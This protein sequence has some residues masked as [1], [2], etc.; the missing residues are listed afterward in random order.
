MPDPNQPSVTS[1]PIH[2][3]STMWS[4]GR[5]PGEGG[6][7]DMPSFARAAARLGYL[8]IEVNYVIPEAGVHALLSTDHVTI[9]SFHSPTPRIKT[10]DG[11]HSDALNLASLDQ[12]ERALAVQRALTTIDSAAQ[13]GARYVVVHLGGVEGAMLDEERRLRRLYDT[14]V[15]IGR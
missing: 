1:A 3:L 12:D 14:G 8:H 7:D 15:Q 6:H 9:A 13:A 2:A 10:P 11:R 5:F 4:Q